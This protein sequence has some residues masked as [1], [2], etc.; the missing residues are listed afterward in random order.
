PLCSACCLC[1]WP[2][3]R[4][5]PRSFPTR[6]SSDL[7][8]TTT[9]AK[10]ARR[11]IEKDR[12]SVM[13]V[14]VDVHRPAAILQ[15]ERLAGEVGARFCPSDAGEKPEVIAR[16]ALEESRRQHIDVLIVDTAGRMH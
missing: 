14:S 5:A 10:L 2:G 1:S 4:C 11:L 3:Q 12:K 8:K 15:L 13:L 9:A 6:R 16:R 7:G